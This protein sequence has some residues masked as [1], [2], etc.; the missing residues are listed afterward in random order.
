MDELADVI[1]N[2]NFVDGVVSIGMGVSSAWSS[3]AVSTATVDHNGKVTGVA[4]GTATISYTVIGTGGCSATTVSRHVTVIPQPNS[5]VLVNGSLNFCVGDSLSLTAATS[6]GLTYEWL[7]NGID[8]LGANQINFIVRETGTYTLKVT[9]SFGCSSV[10]DPIICF[11]RNC[12]EV[13]GFVRY[14][15]NSTTPLSNTRVFCPRIPVF[16][17]PI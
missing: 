4:A 12:N 11:T 13:S 6:T 2:T 15:N 8:I 7:K 1:P 16:H 5:T 14:S 17:L 9:N 3:D 10:S